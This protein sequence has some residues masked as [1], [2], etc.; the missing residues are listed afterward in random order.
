VR[1]F[2][3]VPGYDKVAR[4]G[5]SGLEWVLQRTAVGLVKVLNDAAQ[6]TVRQSQIL[7]EY[8]KLGLEVHDHADIR[9][10]DLEQVDR[11]IGWLNTKYKTLA[12]TEGAVAGAVGAPGIAPDIVALI[13]LNLRAIGEYAT[14]C[15]FRI[16]SQEERLFAF[17]VLNLA[18]SPDD[19]AKHVALAQLVRISKDV[20]SKKTWEKLNHHAY[21]H[22]VRA[23][24]ESLGTRLTK[25]KLAETIPYAG[26]VIGG[27]F[28]AYFTS[29]VCDSA[30]FLYRERFLAE[31]YGANVI[32]A[33][34]A[35]ATS[36]IA[37]TENP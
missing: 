7:A 13:A 11:A 28:N 32:E 29:K 21:V 19:T 25:A 24:A 3:K 31:K 1:A 22:I 26:A 36:F 27:G 33:P 10:L 5:K 4:L 12:L 9:K 8:R 35:P 20:A 18:S 37:D 6:R 2:K 16:S 34:V 15:G 14:Y 30:F 17:N 23:I